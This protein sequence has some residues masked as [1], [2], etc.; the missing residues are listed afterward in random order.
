MQTFKKNEKLCGKIDTDNLFLNGDSFFV[1]PFRIVF[2][3]DSNINLLAPLRLQVVVPKKKIDLAV[4][5]NKLKRY[6]REAFRKNKTLLISNLSSKN[7]KIDFA[8]IYQSNDLISYSIIE[9]KIKEI[10]SRF[11]DSL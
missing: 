10:F 9:K 1:N 6:T 3:K 4:N 7:K 8:L 2:F 5:R 11:S